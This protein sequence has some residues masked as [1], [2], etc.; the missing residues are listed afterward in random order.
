MLQPPT[1]AKVG[2]LKEIDPG[3]QLYA[4]ENSWTGIG[5]DGA[6]VL[7]LNGSALF[8]EHDVSDPLAFEADWAQ[9]QLVSY[10]FPS[11]C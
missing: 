7:G 2:S 11:G 8:S 10:A 3:G 4:A 5:F 9:W 1:L 6:I